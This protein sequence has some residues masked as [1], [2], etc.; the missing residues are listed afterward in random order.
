L[1]LTT[2]LSE[3]LGAD[4]EVLLIHKADGFVF[5][6]FKL[7]VMFGRTVAEAVRHPYSD[8]AKPGVRFVQATVQGIDPVARGVE[9]DAGYVDGDVMVL[10]LGAG[11]DPGATPGLAEGGHEFYTLARAFAARDLLARFRG[12]R[13]VV[14]VTS[15]L[16]KCPP[17]TERDGIVGARLPRTARFARSEVSLVMPFGH[18]IPPSPTASAALLAF[19]ER[20][21][22]WHLE[23][24][25]RVL[26][27][28]RGA[29]VLSDGKEVPHD[30]FLGVPVHRAPAVVEESSMC[31]DGW[32]PV[33]PSTLEMTM[34]GVY[35]VGDVTSVGTPK[36]GVRAEGQAAV[37]AAAVIAQ[38]R[39]LPTSETYDGRGIC[40][41]EF[42][43]GPDRTCR[44]HLSRQ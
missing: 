18:P 8:L 9:T 22:I 21:I 6:F 29:V 35:A 15:T 42:G 2:R 43:H 4:A 39:G 38:H 31:V 1:E 12:G 36:A 19:E 32:I 26:E 7:D 23:R 40:Y 44:R 33:N 30:L 20:G 14:G 5:G 34:P 27:P 11:L 13:V 3:E 41:V 25:V 37:V 17:A 24:A 10:A 16:F 28:G